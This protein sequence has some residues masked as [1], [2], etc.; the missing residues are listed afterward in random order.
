MTIKEKE[1]DN[2]RASLLKR[3]DVRRVNIGVGKQTFRSYLKT[4]IAPPAL[5][6]R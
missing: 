3:E 5:K 2:D 4:V 6:K 1:G